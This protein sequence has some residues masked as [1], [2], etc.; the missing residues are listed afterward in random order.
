MRP[1]IHVACLTLLAWL[2]SAALASAQPPPRDPLKPLPL[3]PEVRPP[4]APQQNRAWFDPQTGATYNPYAKDRWFIPYYGPP[5]STMRQYNPWTGGAG[6]EGMIYNPY[7][8]KYQPGKVVFN[9]FTGRHVMGF[10][11][12]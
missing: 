12:R 10:S 11:L 3:I 2:T 8:G 5:D 1:C 7:T 4:A 6:Q 9:P